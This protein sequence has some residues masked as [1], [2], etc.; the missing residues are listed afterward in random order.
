[1]GSAQQKKIA[2]F[3]VPTTEI[4]KSNYFRSE[5]GMVYFLAVAY[6]AGRWI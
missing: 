5:V 3:Q 2:V 6:L 4:C 1:M